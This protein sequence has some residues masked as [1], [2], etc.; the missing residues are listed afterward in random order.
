SHPHRPPQGL[1]TR[2]L[3][4]PPR[5][6]RRVDPV[7]QL[8]QPAQRLVV[9]QTVSHLLLRPLRHEG[10]RPAHLPRLPLDLPRRR[11]GPALDRGQRAASDLLRHDVLPPH[12]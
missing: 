2:P 5:Q 8:R 7:W 4:H 10:R 11:L 12:H 9:A 6:A 3:L 1:H